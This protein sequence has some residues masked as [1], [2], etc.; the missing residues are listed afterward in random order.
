MPINNYSRRV[1]PILV[2]MWYIHTRRPSKCIQSLF[3]SKTPCLSTL[4]SQARSADLQR[5][6]DVKQQDIDNLN[7]SIQSKE[8]DLLRICEE[9]AR[10]MQDVEALAS[11]L[12]QVW[13]G[14]SKD[15]FF[16]AVYFF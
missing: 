5:Q 11:S 15:G 9:H 2:V 13:T 3:Q 4:C 8:M 16:A 10:K 6:L 12:Q 7:M 14:P 1:F